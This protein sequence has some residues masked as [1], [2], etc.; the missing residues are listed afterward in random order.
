MIDPSPAYIAAEALSKRS[1]LS[2]TLEPAQFGAE[3]ECLSIGGSHTRFRCFTLLYLRPTHIEHVSATLKNYFTEGL[4]ITQ[5]ANP[6]I[7]KILIEKGI[8]YIDLQGNCHIASEGVVLHLEGRKPVK[9]EI[10]TTNKA[11]EMAG[12]KLT[13]AILSGLVDASASYRDM[14]N[15][16]GISIGAVGPALDGLD[17]SGFLMFRGQTGRRKLINKRKLFDRWVDAFVDRIKPK[18]YLGLFESRSENDW[19]NLDIYKFD[20]RWGGEPAGAIL[21]NYLYPDVL[22]LYIDPKKRLHLMKEAKLR[23]IDDDSHLFAEGPVFELYESFG[24]NYPPDSNY[25]LD[26]ENPLIVYA[27]LVGLQEPRNVEVA[28]L[29]YEKHIAGL[30]NEED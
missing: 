19:R 20:F 2:V 8:N 3:G 4:L 14:A 29:I 1:G 30:F 18:L 21:T 15:A 25:P 5:Y 16:A 28:G 12:M 26:V 7:S 23:K 24:G 6:Q 27:D 22:T 9:S 10:I 13:L 11:F 17:K